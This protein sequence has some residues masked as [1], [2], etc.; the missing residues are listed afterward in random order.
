MLDDVRVQS[1]LWP[2]TGKFVFHKMQLF[3][4]SSSGREHFS[5]TSSGRTGSINKLITELS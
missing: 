2:Q 5:C 3:L 1:S 4:Q